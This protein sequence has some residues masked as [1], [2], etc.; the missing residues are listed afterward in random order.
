MCDITWNIHGIFSSGNINPVSSNVGNIIPIIQKSIAVCCERVTFE[1]NRPSDK[2]VIIKSI[3]PEQGNNCMYQTP[4]Y[5]KD[6]AYSQRILPDLKTVVGED[7][8]SGQ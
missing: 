1:I 2:Q 8:K 6:N 5:E 3:E 7:A 4:N